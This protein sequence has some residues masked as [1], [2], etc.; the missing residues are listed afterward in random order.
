VIENWLYW[1]IID[2]VAPSVLHARSDATALL[3]VAYV[4]MVIYGYFV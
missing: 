3:F 4:L 1:I 2:G